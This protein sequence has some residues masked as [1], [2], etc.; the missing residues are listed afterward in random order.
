MKDIIREQSVD[1]DTLRDWLEHGEPVFV[2]DVRDLSQREEWQ[3]PGSHHLNAYKRLNEG[4]YTVMDE[5]QIPGNTKVVTVCTAGRTSKMA[6]A[7][8]SQ[9][10]IDA[11]S[12][13]GGM[14]KW[15]LAW[16]V[17]L[18]KFNDF[19]VLQVRRTGKGCLSYIVSSSNEAIVIDASLPL[20]VYHQLLNKYALTIKY[21]AETHIHADHLSRAKSV[22]E[23]YNVP[24]FMPVPN[25]V[26][27]PHQAATADTVFTI[28][29]IEMR[30]MITPGHTLESVSYYVDT[31]A[32]FTGD[33][34]FIDGVG[35]PDLKAGDD[36]ETRNR[37]SLLY[38]SLQKIVSLQDSMFIFPG[39]TSHPIPFDHKIIASTIDEAKK[40]LKLLTVPQHEFVDTLVKKIPAPPPNYLTIVEKNL[41]GDVSGADATELEAGA[42]RCA[43]S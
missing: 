13:E 11:Y 43:I 36:N 16:N 10:G 3:I 37:A 12:L 19:E 17:A 33:T 23:F 15:S 20:E 38:E 34:L 5:I 39:H 32:I 4:D 2:L 14:R 24:L 42:N 7:L 26:Q 29:E 35:R 25:K 6:A 41:S 30:T 18:K 22:A 40:R 1:A 28:G 27:F 8:L 21:V 9:K 31:E